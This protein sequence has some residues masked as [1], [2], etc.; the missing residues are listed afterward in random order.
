[1]RT[2]STLTAFKKHLRDYRMNRRSKDW[3][4]AWMFS[5]DATCPYLQFIRLN[6]EE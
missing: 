4:R 3:V 1:M 5:A 2:L 6:P